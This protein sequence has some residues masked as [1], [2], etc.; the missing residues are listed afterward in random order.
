MQSNSVK[1]H[2][3]DPVTHV[4]SG[5]SKRT[6]FNIEQ[7]F[8][9]SDMTLMNVGMYDTQQSDTVGLYYP[10][11][12][13][14]MQTLKKVT[15]KCN[16]K[17]I[18]ELN[19]CQALTTQTALSNTNR[20]SDDMNRQL[21]LNGM[22]Y[23]VNSNTTALSGSLTLSADYTSNFVQMDGAPAIN[24]QVVIPKADGMQ[25]GMIK[26]KDIF[27]LLR[28]TPILPALPNLTLEIEWNTSANDYFLDPAHAGGITPNLVPTLPVLVFDEVLDIRP[29]QVVSVI[30]Y[31]QRLVD[32]FEIPIITAANTVG[33]LH[34]D[35]S[36]IAFK[37]KFLKRLTFINLPSTDLAAANKWLPRNNR[38]IAQKGEK[39]QLIV[40]SR[41]FIPGDGIS[42]AAM[43]LHYYNA[44]HGQL[45]VPYFAYLHSKRDDQANMF[46]T[47]LDPLTGQYSLG[48][49]RVERV[50]DTLGI[51]YQRL[52]GD[53]AASREAFSLLVIGD[54]ARTL[55]IKDDIIRTDY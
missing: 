41:A 46:D 40:N 32:R 47:K 15:L 38:S 13:G 34:T 3:V 24:N 1:T 37:D 53:T 31:E 36:S 55:T 44:A 26:L 10:T 50:I 20:Y 12:N 8:I 28:G 11:F 9:D 2:Y 29:D 21:L 54:V 7:T 52:Y 51:N 30:K 39:I 17:T 48:G 19:H 16:G 23:Q 18:D 35:N 4:V 33:A 45:N 25:S 42:N 22:G 43:K 27:G 6:V 5:S 14:V 49:C